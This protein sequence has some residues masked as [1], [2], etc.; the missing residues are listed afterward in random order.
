[1]RNQSVR[2]F[3]IFFQNCSLIFRSRMTLFSYISFDVKH[4]VW[5][6]ISSC[7]WNGKSISN[8]ILRYRL[9]SC[10]ATDFKA[11]CQGLKVNKT[12]K[13][14]D[15]GHNEMLY[16]NKAILGQNFGEILSVRKEECGCCKKTL[17]KGRNIIRSLKGSNLT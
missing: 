12:L 11:L 1:M 2:A 7:C 3:R 15:I 4:P 8:C 5:P 10:G 13:I 17:I 14:L 6:R 16:D 9:S